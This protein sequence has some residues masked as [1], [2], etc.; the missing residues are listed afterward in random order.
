MANKSTNYRRIYMNVMNLTGAW[1]GWQEVPGGGTTDAALRVTRYGAR[2]FLFGKGIDD[3]KIY[4]N[5]MEPAGTWSGWAGL[6]GDVATVTSITP[7]EGPDGLL[8]AFAVT[9]QQQIVYTTNSTV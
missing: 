9:P 7:A 3:N 5:T 6:P 8:Y 2:P 4:V 1:S